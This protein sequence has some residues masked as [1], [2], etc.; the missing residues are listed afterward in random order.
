MWASI[1]KP[2]PELGWRGVARGQV[3]I[4]SITSPQFTPFHS[5]KPSFY[6]KTFHLL[7]RLNFMRT[8]VQ[9]EQLV[10]Y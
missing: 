4:S 7:V 1:H 3:A 6:S 5:Q 9:R 10:M 2:P 8:L